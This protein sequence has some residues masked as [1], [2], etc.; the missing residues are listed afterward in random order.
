MTVMVQ[1]LYAQKIV[2]VPQFENEN[3]PEIGYW[4]ITPTMI[5]E[6]NKIEAHIDS[7]AKNCKYTMLFLTSREGASFYDFSLLHSFFQKLVLEAHKKGLKVGLQLWGNYQDKSIEGSQR[8]IVENEVVLDQSGNA[9]FTASAKYIRFPDRLLKSDL[10]KVYA[11]KK[12]GN[13][14]YDP[15]TL[16]EITHKCKSVLPN[17]E[18]VEIEINGGET[19][20]GLTACIMTQEYC[21]QSSNW[22][23]VEINGFVEAIKAYSDIHWDGFALDEYGN[24]FVVRS[25]EAKPGDNF[26]ARWYSEGMAREFNKA[27][28]Q[29]LTKVLFTGRYAPTGMPEL[30]INAINTYMDFMRKGAVRVENAVYQKSKEIL[31]RNIFNGIHNTYH[32]SLINDEIWANGIGWWNVARAYGQTDEKTPTAIQMGVAMA[33]PMN[34]M[35][36]QYYD[37]DLEPVITKSLFDLRYGIRTHYH[38]LNDKRPL[39]FDLEFPEAIEK[40]NKVENCARL[41]NKFNPLLPE[42]KLLVVFGIEALSN[43]YPY[44]SDRGFYDINDKMKVEERAVEIWEAGY[45]NALVP[46]D[47]I[48]NKKITLDFDGNPLMNG[49][50]F[51]AIVYLNPQFAKEEEIKFLE[52]FVEK[53]GKLMIEGRAEYDFNGKDI[54]KRFQSIYAKATVQNYSIENLSKLGIQKNL[55]PDGCKTED[56]AYVFTNKESL[57]SSKMASFEVTI[58]GNLYSGLYKGLLAISFDANSGIKKLAAAGFKEVRKNKEVILS[59]NQPTDVFV[60]RQTKTTQIIIADPAGKLTPVNNKLF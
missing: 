12:T 36:N 44:E 49:H 52:S 26:R 58:N 15:S 28:G 45:L 27:T 31:G 38:A 42:V 60:E 57:Y 55:L 41:L 2:Y 13:G 25:I 37:K 53:G 34:A 5:K 50:K 54:S 30:R 4:F 46:S 16:Q 40:I 33:H 11:F 32:N 8:M 51:D 23:D 29:N 43:W 39:R 7:I 48:A 17:K 3:H 10:F 21:S 59:F 14:F 22:D 35:Y 6:E 19:V 1:I 24:K 56:G 9:K 18:T 20:K 47:L